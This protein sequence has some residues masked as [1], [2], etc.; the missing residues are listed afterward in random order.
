MT[1]KLTLTLAIGSA[2]MLS[3]CDDTK[4]PGFLKSSDKNTQ[5]P[6]PRPSETGAK[7][8]RDVEAPE[9]FKMAEKGLWDG[10]PSLGGVWVAHPDAKDP[11][12]V[13]IRNQANGKSVV[14]ALFRRERSVP[15][16]RFQVSSDAAAELGMLA[17][18]PAG[19]SVTALR[20]AE[21]PAEAPT[22]KLSA[23]G[24]V[25]QSTLQDP[26][27]A[28]AAALDKT[29][30]TSAK[31]PQKPATKASTLSKPYVQLGIFSVEKNANNTA[32]A[33]RQAG[34]NAVIKPGSSNGKSFWRVLAG[35]AA[36]KT[37]RAALLKKIKALGFT[38]AYFVSR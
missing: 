8:T 4:L 36:N 32:E 31:A 33:I 29:E 22:E 23:G 30:A 3:A 24:E 35:P 13:I 2:L 6:K 19:L 28:A 38:D 14:G 21:R 26:I 17:G 18:A 12:R 1:S 5:T 11:E 10:R 34:M 15:G 9:I 16:P 7:V 25:K 37:A 20:K 27:A